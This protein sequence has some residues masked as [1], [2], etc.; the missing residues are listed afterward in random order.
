MRRKPD[1]LIPLEISVLEAALALQRRGTT[2]FYGFLLAKVIKTASDRRLLIA[3]GTLYRALHRLERAKLIEAFWEDPQEA[4]REN[5]PR[6]RLYRLTAL[7]EIAVH[8]ARAEQGAGRHLRSLKEDL[9]T[10]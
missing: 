5:R 1:Q 7:S 9:G 4:A 2:A 3:H 6:R 8:R 10:P